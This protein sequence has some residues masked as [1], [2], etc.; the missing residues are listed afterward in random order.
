MSVSVEST[1]KARTVEHGSAT[2]ARKRII[3]IESIV[4]GISARRARS[5]VAVNIEVRHI[6]I[7]F[8]YDVSLDSLFRIG[9]LHR[10]KIFGGFNEQ[11]GDICVEFIS[12]SSVFCGYNACNARTFIAFRAR[13]QAVYHLKRLAVLSRGNYPVGEKSVKKIFSVDRFYVS[14]E[15]G[16]FGFPFVFRVR[17]GYGNFKRLIEIDAVAARYVKRGFPAFQGDYFAACRVVVRY[18]GIFYGNRNRFFFSVHFK[19]R[20]ENLFVIVSFAFELARSIQL[21]FFGRDFVVEKKRH[22]VY[23]FNRYFFTH[24]RRLKIF[25]FA[26]YGYDRFAFFKRLKNSV[27]YFTYFFVGDGISYLTA[28]YGFA[29]ETDLSA[30]ADFVHKIYRNVIVC[31]RFYRRK[32]SAERYAHGARRRKFSVSGGNR[33]F[34]YVFGGNV[35]PLVNGGNRF[36]RTL[37]TAFYRILAV[38]SPYRENVAENGL[39]V[40][41]VNYQIGNFGEIIFTAAIVC[42]FGARTNSQRKARHE[43][44]KQYT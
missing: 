20:I 30:Y 14:F 19:R 27:F 17:H 36:V 9:Q 42:L 21:D 37:P 35:T 15:N 1:C 24:K 10:K 32:V 38:G 2:F 11:S 7:V 8:K 12:V 4:H 29:V 43:N 18:A 6:D 34:A 26:R 40:V 3:R 22:V 5:S 25:P 33:R 31:V 23:D 28:V 44:R 13:Y 41:F 39:Y 16:K